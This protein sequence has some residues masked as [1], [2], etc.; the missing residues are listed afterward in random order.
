MLITWA[1]LCRSST[2]TQMKVKTQLLKKIYNLEKGLTTL[3]QKPGDAI[4]QGLKYVEASI[5]T[6]TM[7]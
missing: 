4:A 6:F 7:Y 1:N 3:I 2:H 5:F